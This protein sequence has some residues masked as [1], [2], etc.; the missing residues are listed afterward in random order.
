M[1]VK[2]PH[3]YGTGEEPDAYNLKN[4]PDPECHVCKGTG[5][6]DDDGWSEMTAGDELQ[7]ARREP[8]FP[9]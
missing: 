9:K 3:C 5:E 2:C 7:A 8:D 4:E 6:V 1:Y